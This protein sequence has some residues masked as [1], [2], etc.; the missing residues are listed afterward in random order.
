MRGL[1]R[2][3]DGF[4][5]DRLYVLRPIDVINRYVEDG[6]GDPEEFAAI[7][8]FEFHDAL[9]RLDDRQSK[10]AMYREVLAILGDLGKG[11]GA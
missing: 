7:Y 1:W 3:F 11:P 8:T 5:E 2:L 10:E 6:Q 9:G 4:N